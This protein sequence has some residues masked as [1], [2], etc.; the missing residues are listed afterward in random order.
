M[1]RNPEGPG[2]PLSGIGRSRRWGEASGREGRGV[3]ATSAPQKLQPGT[4]G[5]VRLART[6]QRAGGVGP[7]FGEVPTGRDGPLWVPPLPQR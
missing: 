4:G 7:G 3:A 2:S 1:G 6:L 5:R